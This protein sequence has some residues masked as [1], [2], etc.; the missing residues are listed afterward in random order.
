[1]VAAC[2]QHTTHQ[3]QSSSWCA[4]LRHSRHAEFCKV[5]PHYN[6]LH[7]YW[8]SSTAAHDC[9][10]FHDLARFDLIFAGAEALP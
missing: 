7:H 4:T 10:S 9:Q 3:L 2:K 5:S 1:M 8:L 6:H